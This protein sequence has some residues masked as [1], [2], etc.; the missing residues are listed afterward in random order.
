MLKLEELKALARY[1]RGEQDVA[2]IEYEKTREV[3]YSRGTVVDGVPMSPIVNLIQV[4]NT[5]GYM[6]YEA[7]RHGQPIYHTGKP[8]VMD[9]GMASMNNI[10]LRDVDRKKPAEDYDPATLHPAVRLIEVPD[11]GRFLPRG[12][13]A[14]PTLTPVAV[15]AMGGKSPAIDAYDRLYM[16]TAF[17]LVTNRFVRETSAN[18]N[19][20][21]I[22]VAPT[23]TIVAWALNAKENNST[24]HA[25]VN[26]LQAL[27]HHSPRLL[28][29]LQGYRLY[30]TLKPCKMCAAMIRH[31]GKGA[32]SVIYGQDDTGDDARGTALDSKQQQWLLTQTIDIGDSSQSVSM[33]AKLH[34]TREATKSHGNMSQTLATDEARNLML[35]SSTTSLDRELRATKAL[36]KEGDKGV[37]RVY[38]HIKDFLKVSN[39]SP[40]QIA[41]AIVEIY[42]PKYP[43][44][45][46]D[47]FT[48]M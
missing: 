3:Y 18:A 35:M 14:M 33:Q 1:L 25:E 47:H 20:G 5:H 48:L 38:R 21:A 34:T 30:T 19:I 11:D 41:A 23:G 9:A 4:L 16:M 12:E 26:L 6:G 2:L 45:G 15:G 27:H 7:L 24:F 46:P 42:S 31:V 28:S 22:L 36:G 29:D 13:F 37:L 17:A 39:V 44:G 8:S 10:M 32:I 43:Y 40:K